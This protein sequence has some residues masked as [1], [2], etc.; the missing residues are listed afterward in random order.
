MRRTSVGI[1]WGAAVLALVAACSTSNTNAERSASSD[2][3]ESTTP[4][5]VT[6]SSSPPG[7]VQMA[8]NPF[9]GDE[10]WIAYQGGDSQGNSIRLRL[11]H[12][13]GTGDRLIDTGQP[14]DNTQPDWSPDGTRVAVT[15]QDALY[16]YDVTTGTTRQLLACRRPCLG[17]ANLAYAPDGEHIAFIRYLGPLVNGVPSDCGIWIGDLKS[18]QVRQLTSHTNPPCDPF[19]NSLDWSPN[20]KRLVY[21]RAV[22][23]ASA[24]VKS[25]IYSIAVDGTDE[26]RL[27][28]PGLVGGEPAY[29]PDG[30]WIVFNTNPPDFGEGDSQL[31]RMRPDG[32]GIEQLTHYE[33]VRAFTPTYSPD[34]N[35]IIFSVFGLMLPG[36]AHALWVIPANGGDPVVIPDVP[37]TQGN[38]QP[39]P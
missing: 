39:T 37:G 23:L 26:R 25:A 32:S 1:V 2:P 6:T 31:Y 18:G 36:G 4:A 15:V 5:G 35:S 22:Q 9:T 14:G 12:P 29:S 10:S 21:F 38:W 16:E 24:N 30:R 27:T 7:G 11:V 3:T 13:D 33:D 34:G 8:E 19:E 20:G 17:N 28:P